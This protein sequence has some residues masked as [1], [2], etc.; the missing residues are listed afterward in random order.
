MFNDTADH[1]Q[2]VYISNMPEY[3]PD[4]ADNQFLYNALTLR[5]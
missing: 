2:A 3:S 4:T 5:S 1:Y